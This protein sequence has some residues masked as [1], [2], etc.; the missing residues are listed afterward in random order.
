MS[1]GSLNRAGPP[2][3]MR[4]YG[5]DQLH[6]ITCS[7]YCRMPL[8]GSGGWP[9]SNPPKLGVPHFSRPWREVGRSNV[10]NLAARF[11][12]NARS[13]APPVISVK[14]QDSHGLPLALWVSL[15]WGDAAI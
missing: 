15:S 8:L 12:K 4:Y 13:G 1:L 14:V 5:A 7:C 2:F 6:F 11:S 3:S 9:T 10:G